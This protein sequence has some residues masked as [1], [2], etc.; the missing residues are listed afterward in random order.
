METSLLPAPS[1]TPPLAN[2][3]IGP[4]TSFLPP[5]SSSDTGIGLHQETTAIKRAASPASSSDLQSRKRMKIDHQPSASTQPYSTVPEMAS[6]STPLVFCDDS[7]TKAIALSHRLLEELTCGC[8][9][10]LCYNVSVLYLLIIN[11]ILASITQPVFL[12]PCQH[13]FCGRYVFPISTY[14]R[15][16]ID[17]LQL[18]RAMD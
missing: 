13:F 4:D 17:L 18:H 12:L 5:S 8:C 7:A 15:F 14:P 10:E 3:S 9:T 16:F 2:Q 6:G 1:D 11:H